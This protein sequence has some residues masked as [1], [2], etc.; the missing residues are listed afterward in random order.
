M[1]GAALAAALSLVVAGCGFGGGG[2]G[3]PQAVGPGESVVSIIAPD[4]Y[5]ADPV[6]LPYTRRT[7]CRI[8]HIGPGTAADLILAGADE[9]SGLIAGGEAQPLNIELVPVW[10][11]FP[12]SLRSAP[13]ITAG[14]V[15]YGIPATWRPRVIMWNRKRIKGTPNSWSTFYDPQF[16]RLLTLPD[17]PLLIADAALYLAVTR[18]GL[19][20]ENPFE[21]TRAQFD[22][23]VGLVRRQRP[24]VRSYWRRPADAAALLRRGKAILGVATPAFAA[25]LRAAKAPIHDGIP[26]EGVTATAD[27]WL[28]GSAATHPNCAYLWLR[29]ISSAAVQAKLADGLDALPANLGACALT[30]KSDCAAF[31]PK[32][33][34]RL[35]S[36][37]QA[38]CGNGESTCLP[39]ARWQEA[40]K[41]IT[42]GR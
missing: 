17:D 35:Y 6:A 10:K 32:A 19:G 28:L 29:W 34:V 22:A 27:A 11:D 15:P 30:S 42:S 31:D 1:A 5:V 40:W 33:I 41:A 9:A 26:I 38:A 18:P 2:G 4:A 12:E 7:G 13:E 21:L 25:S 37:P 14:G 20:I 39:F 8:E 16:K 36:P 24:L 3:V 23:A